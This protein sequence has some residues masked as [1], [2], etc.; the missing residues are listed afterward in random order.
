MWGIPRPPNP[1]FRGRPDGTFP[2]RWMQGFHPRLRGRG[3]GGPPFPFRGAARGPNPRFASRGDPAYSY[4]DADSTQDESWGGEC[5]PPEEL[6]YDRE[7]MNRNFPGQENIDC[8]TREMSHVDYEDVVPEAASYGESETPDM[9][10]RGHTASDMDYRERGASHMGQR[11]RGS[12]NVDYREREEA[13]IIYRERLTPAVTSR[14]R[15]ALEYR[16]RF[17]AMLALRERDAALLALREREAAVLEFRE[18]EAAVLELREREAAVLELREREAAVLELRERETAVLGFREREAAVLELREREAAVL[19]LRER[20]AAMLYRERLPPSEDYRERGVSTHYREREIADLD[21]RKREI[22]D[23]DYRER[24]VADLDYREREVADLDYREREVVDLDYR[25]REVADLD[26]REREVVDL[27]Y[28]EREVADLDYR[29]RDTAALRYRECERGQEY[30]GRATA[31]RDY[32]E[33]LI[34]DYSERDTAPLHYREREKVTIDYRKRETLIINYTD[35]ETAD[36]D[37]RESETSGGDFSGRETRSLDYRGGETA[38]VDCRGGEAEVLKYGETETAVMDHQ[39]KEI[40]GLDYT[41]KETAASDYSERETDKDHKEMES[42]D[43][44]YIKKLTPDTV[45][46]ERVFV[47]E[48]VSDEG[49]FG[50]EIVSEE[51]VFG[52]Y[53]KGEAEGEEGIP[54]LSYK[55]T[56]SPVLTSK[57]VDSPSHYTDWVPPTEEYSRTEDPRVDLSHAG[58]RQEESP[59]ADPAKGAALLESKL[60]DCPGALDRDFRDRLNPD[61]TEFTDKEIA[62]KDMEYPG[63]AETIVEEPCSDLLGSGD[64]DLRNQEDFAQD[65]SGV[66]GDRDFRATGYR[67]EDE[68]LRGGEAGLPADILGSKSLLYDFL[69]L[70]AQELT[71]KH[72]ADSTTGGHGLSPTRAKPPL[73][74]TQGSAPQLPAP[75]RETPAGDNPGELAFLGRQD[76]DYRNMKYRDVD[77]RIGYRQEKPLTK[78]RPREEPLPGSKDK[79]YRRGSLPDGATRVIWLD[80]LPTGASREEI[81]Y[82]L[83]AGEEL[84][85]HRVNLIGFIPGYSLGSV[86]VQFSLVEEAV[87]CMEANK[88]SVTIRGKKVT[89]K[90]IPNSDRWR[91]LQCEAVNVLSKERCWQCSALRSGSD[92]LPLRDSPKESKPV[93]IPAS[94]RGKKRKLKW[95]PTVPPPSQEE[96]RKDRTPPRERSPPASRRQA[97]GSPQTETESTTVI[98]KGISLNSRPDS[99]VKA[100]ERFV[101]L[102][103]S[104]VRIIKNRK[105]ELG[106]PTTFGFIELKDHKEAVRLMVLVR[107]MNPPL[108]VDGIPVTVNLAIGKRRMDPFRIEPSKYQRANKT[109]F[110]SQAKRQ[111]VQRSMFPAYA[112]KAEI[113]GPSYVFD[114]Q[115]GQYLDPLTDKYYDPKTLRKPDERNLRRAAG[116][117]EEGAPRARRGFIED[118]G[119]TLNEDPFKKPLP[120]SM[121]KEQSPPEPQMNPL[122]GLIG[123]YGGDSEE[124]EED[125]EML[126]PP[127]RR[128]P[129][130]RSSQPAPKPPAPKPPALKPP[131]LKPPALKPPA[132]R[133]PA[134]KPAVPKPTALKQTLKLLALKPASKPTSKPAPTVPVCSA[135]D[136]LTDWKKMA[137]LLCRRQFP[138]KEA[139]T[140]H[141]QLSDLHKQNLAIH[142]KIRQSER[143]LAYLQQR[144]REEN[145]SI[146]KRLQQ[147][148]RELE[149]LEREEGGGSRQ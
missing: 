90:Y 49:L 63:C 119:N 105:N 58:C 2:S 110:P 94:Q 23:L 143:E 96:K 26:Y 45:S 28:R 72:G 60:T 59:L 86:C 44:E 57:E 128:K 111:R 79:D 15:D 142:Q 147:A 81:L 40:P 7:E 130:P 18:R 97:K 47:G 14:Q 108:T 65:L 52:D 64:Q 54:F 9:D 33:R 3:V 76:T 10:Y 146:Q 62:A 140:R 117:E 139:L 102:A 67:Q 29:E 95:S 38:Q 11:E 51:R 69:Q 16:E 73:K 133:P 109:T 113:E 74:P 25:E 103:P 55:E 135:Q 48:T 42:H 80:G 1:A 78:G 124:E 61:P 39:V 31:E 132:P 120:P 129:P 77:L 66:S 112:P 21:Y 131:A 37:Y 8:R 41:E 145:Q 12:P 27:D 137:C 83:G 34:I 118:K 35:R 100:L 148:K 104:N 32:R 84:P 98:M 121:M 92:H 114:A 149:E 82:A 50:R 91:C 101:H 141:Q 144:E 46:E 99:V 136:K 56:E 75:S 22:A 125:Q 93:A 127:L 53:S 68:D 71:Q 123:E 122:I 19:A 20:K 17:A 134:P 36:L 107:E 43:T 4:R 89:L 116:E 24:E 88:R 115:S 138:N 13:D 30:R 6:P 87:G 126:L 106:G 70:A 85:D 5:I